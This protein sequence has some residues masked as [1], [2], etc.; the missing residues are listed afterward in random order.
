MRTVMDTVSLGERR[1]Q[2]RAAAVDA[3]A[4]LVG[5]DI[6]ALEPELWRGTRNARKRA[7]QTIRRAGGVA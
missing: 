2:L 7:R 5:H 4:W 3:G 1:A 6:R